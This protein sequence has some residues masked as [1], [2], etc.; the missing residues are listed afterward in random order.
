MTWTICG[1]F[2]GNDCWKA[3]WLLSYL[4]LT[5]FPYC[6]A[7]HLLFCDQG[8]CPAG[9][10]SL[11]FLKAIMLDIPQMSLTSSCWYSHFCGWQIVFWSLRAWTENRREREKKMHLIEAQGVKPTL[12]FCS[13]FKHLQKCISLE[14]GTQ[15]KCPF[16]NA[17]CR[18]QFAQLGRVSMEGKCRWFCRIL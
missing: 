15:M 11:F 2:Y 12:L 18:H 10:K 9:K 14:G 16:S 1:W 7:F 3:I 13:S 8:Q 5:A 4:F 17:I 6:F